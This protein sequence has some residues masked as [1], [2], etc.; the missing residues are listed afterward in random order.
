MNQSTQTRELVFETDAAE[1]DVTSVFRALA[2]QPRLRILRLLGDRLMNVTEIAEALGVPVSTANSHVNL[3][4]EAGLLLTE[5]RP[6]A[7]GSQKV[8]TRAF[9][10]LRLYLPTAAPFEGKQIETSMP[11]GAY[12]D[13]RV[14]PSCGLAS[15]E[16]IIGLF[17]DPGS[18]YEPNRVAAQLLWFHCGYVEY[19][20]PQR[21]PSSALLQSVHLALELCSEAP[22]H[23]DDW[24]SDIT[25]WINEVKIGTWTSPADFGG[26][27]G[28]L[29]PGWWETHSSQYGLLKLWQVTETGSLVDGLRVSDV[30]VPD[31]RVGES[32]FVSVRIGVE[33]DA[34]HV[35]GVN[36]FGRAFGNYPQDIVLRLKYV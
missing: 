31:L 21:L 2:S 22:L 11:V 30:R 36:V 5:H 16:G 26:Q 7:R 19:R 23:H 34:R 27:R 14:T 20:F 9:D 32:E 24:P 29:T 25:V 35:G 12:V 13:C 33:A 15:E 3:L 4:E 10:N 8:C 28:R 17:D 18:F 1:G 6:A